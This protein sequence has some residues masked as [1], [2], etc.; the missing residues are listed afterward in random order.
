MTTDTF[1]RFHQLLNRARCAPLSQTQGY[2]SA[3]SNI[4][5]I[6]YWGKEPLYLQI[7]L[8]SSISFTLGGFRSYTVVHPTPEPG[9]HF[10]L[11]GHRAVLPERM[12]TVLTKILQGLGQK[13][14]LCINSTGNFPVACG[15]ASSA[16]GGAALIGALSDSF[17]LAEVFSPEEYTLWLTE[18]ARL[19]SGSATRSV[20]PAAFVLW[21]RLLEHPITQTHSIE[22]HRDF[23]NLEH[24]VVVISSQEKAVSSSQGHMS[25][26]TS[27]LFPLR[28]AA[29]PRILE[30]IK[31]ALYKGDWQTL[32]HHAERDAFAMHAVMQTM[33]E[34][35][36]YLLPQTNSF[37]NFFIRQRDQHA[38]RAFWTL[39]AGP[40]IHLL[41]HKEDFGRVE[42]ILQTIAR[43]LN[44][45][46]TVYFNKTHAP[47][48]IGADQIAALPDTLIQEKVI[49]LRR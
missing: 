19:L 20:L 23:Q 37:L 47:I 15:I 9:I 34:P 31:D 8:N 27:P 3:P 2:C 33:Q 29:L 22:A 7:P 21:E 42:D 10:S 6:K 17:H 48:A 18:G 32:T 24:G 28:H 1:S 44:I 45:P 41:F 5:L 30:E 36:C 16:S 49:M 38:I 39:D 35:V 14:A 12:Q 46:L 11:N 40:N 4:A 26:I 13:T 25:A 43:T